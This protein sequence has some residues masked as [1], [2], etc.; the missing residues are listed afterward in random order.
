[1]IPG[2]RKT[3]KPIAPNDSFCEIFKNI[4]NLT[5]NFEHLTKSECLVKGVH[6]LLIIVRH[7]CYQLRMSDS[8]EIK[9]WI[10]N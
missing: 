3:L 1:M 2:V 7:E 10:P 4:I 5:N 8:R 9:T 6:I